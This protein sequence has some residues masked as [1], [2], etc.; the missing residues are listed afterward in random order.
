MK[1]DNAEKSKKHKEERISVSDV[2]HYRHGHEWEGQLGSGG[3]V[4]KLREISDRSWHVVFA[5]WNAEG[6]L[7]WLAEIEESW[8]IRKLCRETDGQRS[9]QN[10]RENQIFKSY[11]E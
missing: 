8:P 10:E 11:A 1:H 4:Q 7:H 3:I 9:G 6:K 5:K 2:G